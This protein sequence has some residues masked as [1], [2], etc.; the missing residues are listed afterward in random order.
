MSFVGPKKKT[1]T[2][3]WLQ[4][5]PAEA[6]GHKPNEVRCRSTRRTHTYENGF[7]HGHDTCP[8]IHSSHLM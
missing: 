5:L 1:R 2:A 3:E 8:E 7:L 4:T 6:D